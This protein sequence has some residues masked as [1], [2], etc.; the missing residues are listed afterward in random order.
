MGC[1][2]DAINNLFPTSWLDP[3]GEMPLNDKYSVQIDITQVKTDDGIKVTAVKTPPRARTAS[4]QD[5]IEMALGMTSCDEKALDNEEKKS[6]EPVK[7][8]DKKPEDSDKTLDD[9]KEKDE[10]N[11][12]HRK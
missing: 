5:A 9:D 4:I 6:S 2:D 12:Y 3:Y 10:Q 1:M 11:G 7:Q 8:E